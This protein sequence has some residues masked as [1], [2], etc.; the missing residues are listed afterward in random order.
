MK[1][2]LPLLLLALALAI[3]CDDYDSFT[4]SP[5][6]T[7]SMSV[8]TVAWDTLISTIP[9]PTKVLTV[10]NRGDKGL[11]I[12]QVKVMQGGASP[13][14]VN[15]DGEWLY[16]GEGTDF[17]VRRRDSLIVR[18]EC[19]LPP[20][21]QTSPLSIEDVLSFTLESGV[22]QEVVLQA[23]AQ[24][25][26]I[27]HGM[28]LQADSVFLTDLPYV[29]YDSLR[30]DSGVTLI[31][32]AGSTL[33]FHDGAALDVAGTL[34]ALGEREKPVTLRG[35]RTD[36]MFPYLPYDNTPGRWQG[37]CLRSSSR[38]NIVRHCHIRSGR[39]G[40]VADSTS[41]TLDEPQLQM[42]HSIVHNIA[43][44]GLQ[45]TGTSARVA[46]CQLSNTLGHTVHLFGGAYHFVH[47]T[48][49]QFYPFEGERGAA[50]YLANHEGED[51]CHLRQAHFTNCVITGYSDDVLLGSITEG[52]DYRCDYLFDHC[53]LNTPAVLDDDR[54][55]CV[56]WDDKD[57]PLR[58]EKNFRLFDT[59]NFLYDFTPDSL[60]TIRSIALPQAAESYPTDLMGRPRMADGQP[61]AG[62]FEYLPQEEKKGAQ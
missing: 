38:A 23:D 16:G 7:L 25:A 34:H 52:Q 40:I 61:D 12:R 24:D 3:A 47:C 42:E 54:Y 35:D 58:H 29:I 48:I 49:A 17:E 19:T 2:L 21:G 20:T 44:P 60:S 13:F 53:Y 22:R 9:G 4:T 55:V 8:D 14:R 36:R 26:Y 6:A 33:M 45:L 28:T 57:Q 39:Y 46:N 31:L 56:V 10:Y 50:L 18:M 41:T 32:P 15:V 5:D 37:I 11:R 59:D 30:V 51:F 43:G 1:R 62:A 27:V